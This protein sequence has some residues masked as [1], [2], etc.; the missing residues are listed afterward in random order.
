MSQA[1]VLGVDIG[2]SSIKYSL[3]T[4]TGDCVLSTSADYLLARPVPDSLKSTAKTCGARSRDPSTKSR[5]A[6][7][8]STR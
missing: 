8:R 1:V 2:T 7:P 5:G 6:A 3:I 4:P